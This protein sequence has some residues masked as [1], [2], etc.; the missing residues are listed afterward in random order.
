MGLSSVM[1]IHSALKAPYYRSQQSHKILL[2][3]AMVLELLDED[4][5][6]YIYLCGRLLG[7]KS[8]TRTQC[9]A[10][11]GAMP[12]KH[13]SQIWIGSMKCMKHFGHI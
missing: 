2:T 7:T 3:A 8:I 10:S 5:D 4:D 9:L 6:E 13:G 12:S 11:W 1:H